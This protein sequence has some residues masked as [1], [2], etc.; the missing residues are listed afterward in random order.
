M[1][2]QKAERIRCRNLLLEN[3]V[4]NSNDFLDKIITMDEHAICYNTPETK[5]QSKQW[6]E[7][8]LGPVKAKLL[9]SRTKQMVLPF[10]HSKGMIYTN[11]VIRGQTVNV[12][13][14]VSA[15]K[16]SWHH[17]CLKHPDHH[18]NGF[19]F[20]CTGTMWARPHRPE[21][22]AVLGQQKECRDAG[23]P[24]Y[25]PDL[26]LADY[27]LFPRVK[28]TSWTR[29]C[30]RSSGMGSSGTLTLKT[31]PRP[32]ESGQ[33]IMANVFKWRA[34]MLRRTNKNYVLSLY[35]FKLNNSGF[36]SN[37]PLANICKMFMH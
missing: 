12:N 27:F 22:Q 10:F 1:E 8:T 14:I 23:A 4:I 36:S 3:Y 13:Y 34:T 25:S 32:T 31:L 15:L 6:L 19:I 28:A 20:H 5:R 11:I 9:A 24:P 26:V 7:G 18:K 2:E 35:F 33:I 21:G 16:F 17:L 29:R 37:T 30:S